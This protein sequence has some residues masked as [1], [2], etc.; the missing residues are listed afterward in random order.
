VNWLNLSVIVSQS[1][2]SPSVDDNSKLPSL[3]SL[4]Q[5]DTEPVCATLCNKNTM[6]RDRSSVTM[7]T[8][9]RRVTMPTSSLSP[10]SAT[11]TISRSSASK[12]VSLL[13]AVPSVSVLFLYVVYLQS[14]CSFVRF[15][16]VGMC[17]LFSPESQLSY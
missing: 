16:V 17:T 4:S 3:A 11:H 10:V 5:I 13:R 14:G 8:S 7:P 9:C 1:T 15:T 12:N 6:T 2:T